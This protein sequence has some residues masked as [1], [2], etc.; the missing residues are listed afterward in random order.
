M[1][2]FVVDHLQLNS[3]S[4][5]LFCPFYPINCKKFKKVWTERGRSALAL[6]WIPNV[7]APGILANAEVNLDR[8]EIPSTQSEENSSQCLCSVNKIVFVSFEHNCF[9]IQ[10]EE[11]DVQPNIMEI[12]KVI[13][14]EGESKPCQMFTEFLSTDS[15]LQS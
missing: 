14:T 12:E 6:P 4:N 5:L 2:F 7:T 13:H 10:K 11:H 1:L 8:S 9:D 3:S 15:F